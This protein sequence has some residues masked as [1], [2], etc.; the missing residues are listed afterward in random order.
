VDFLNLDGQAGVFL[1][2][3]V[4]N[5][6][7]TGSILLEFAPHHIVSILNRFFDLLVWSSGEIELHY[8]VVL[9][10]AFPDEVELALG[11]RKNCERGYIVFSVGQ[12]FEIFNDEIRVLS[13]F[14]EEV[15]IGFDSF[16]LPIIAL[17]DKIEV[18]LSI[19][20]QFYFHIFCKAVLVLYQHLDPQ[21]L[22]FFQDLH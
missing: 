6:L 20:G 3:G 1:L 14:D 21:H 5:R 10:F 19:T 18:D 9:E 17:E 7:V 13:E 4:T 15:L 12:P 16:E 8:R 2:Y 22:R 11:L